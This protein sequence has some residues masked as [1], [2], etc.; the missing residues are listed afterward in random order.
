MQIGD[1]TMDRFLSEGK[2]V[3]AVRLDE[4]RAIVD[5]NAAFT[6][7]LAL[8][9]CPTGRP[10]RDFLAS[11]TATA[12]EKACRE[13]KA[14]CN[15]SIVSINN[16]IHTV[17]FLRVDEPNGLLLLG[18]KP[19]FTGS[20]IFEQMSAL[21]DEMVNLTRELKDKNALLE[22]TTSKLQA[23]IMAA[24]LAV[25][26]WDADRTVDVWNPAAERIF[27]WPAEEIVNRS[28]IPYD[29]PLM[30]GD[31]RKMLDVAFGGQDFQDRQV[32]R[33]T[34]D[35]RDI[36]L[37]AAMSGIRASDGTVRQVVEILSDVTERVKAEQKQKQWES[38]IQQAQKADS[39][40]ALAGGL[41]H[42]FNNL[43]MIISG[44]ADL[45]MMAADLS[46]DNR[47]LYTEIKDAVSRASVLS[48][49]MRAYSGSGHA[50]IE[51][52][53]LNE[54][55]R[56]A[57]PL[58]QSQARHKLH[59]EF[60]LADD[61][62]E[63]QAD[64]AQ[65]FQMLMNLVTNASEASTGSDQPII[66]RTSQAT[67]AEP[68]EPDHAAG[69]QLPA[70]LYAILEVIDF[71]PG[72]NAE[73]PRQIF[74]PF[75]STKFI[76][77]GL[78]LAAVQGIV[79]GHHGGVFVESGPQQETI[80]RVFLPC[81]GPA[82]LVDSD[83]QSTDAVPASQGTILLADDER[84]VRLVAR[85]LLEKLG[86]DVCEAPDG[87]QAVAAIRGVTHPFRAAILDWSMPG[88]E[89]GLAIHE[90]RQL[91][92]DLPVLICS[93]FGEEQV[94]ETLSASDGVIFLEKPY[95]LKTLAGTLEEVLRES[96]SG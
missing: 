44:N 70:G 91:Q 59:L 29:D 88:M 18:E 71:G 66:L 56:S 16:M 11:E 82:G 14:W 96:A 40:S 81:R 35:G 13:E 33:R 84:A 5:C 45:G 21:N 9:E 57:E 8:G 48:N 23:L 30:N 24:P 2:S 7:L 85:R 69:E 53:D 51:T 22:E 47:E 60:D 75:F 34:R 25:I 26:V 15:L 74:E 4:Q 94:T 65:L 76:G 89:A 64:R 87:Y 77:R 80:F 58:I 83:E 28:S 67:F 39:L 50:M 68:S 3:L 32:S 90:L 10:F 95:Q 49:Q 12:L 46:E 61:L 52:L 31:L 36:E 6:S 17:R 63:I 20:D 1:G 78:G 19:V 54:V 37:L 72:I 73:D 41:A 92:P 42:D 38:H 79:R 27:G 55:L 62:P 43:L 93:G 86:Y